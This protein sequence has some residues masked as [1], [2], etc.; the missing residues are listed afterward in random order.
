MRIADRNALKEKSGR[1]R[2]KRIEK[3]SE[4]LRKLQKL[5]NDP[6]FKNVSYEKRKAVLDLALEARE[7]FEEVLEATEEPLLVAAG[8]GI[9]AM[10]PTHEVRRDLLETVKHLTLI[11][12]NSKE[13]STQSSVK[14]ALE[15][16][17]QADD[18][19]GAITR[20]QQRSATEEEF[21][22]ERPVKLVEELF[23]YRLKR[24]N[25]V[26]ER[27]S[28]IKFSIEG[29]SRLITIILLN[30]LDNSSYWLGINDVKNRKVKV[31]LDEVDD[32]PAIIVSDNGPGI[33]DDLE[34]ITQPFVTKKPEGMGLGL[35]IARRIAENHKARLKLL[36]SS[37]VPGLLSGANIAI[38]FPKRKLK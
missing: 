1:T 10:I 19:V 7:K 17:R 28:R 15:F 25:I 3:F 34:T 2:S 35:Y 24:R 22:A 20:I 27:D 29:S 37:E 33:E 21:S 14:A 13:Q 16:A 4:S 8:I 9:S 11:K 30:M 12:E 36:S 5:L 38:L 31:I 26:Y 32:R 6:A 18:I 23:A